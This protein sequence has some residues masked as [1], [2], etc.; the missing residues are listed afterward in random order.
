MGEALGLVY[1]R[2]LLAYLVYALSA[3]ACSVPRDVSVNAVF[4]I[5]III[6]FDF[7]FLMFAHKIRRGGLKPHPLPC[8]TTCS[9][10]DERNN[11][12][13]TIFRN[14]LV[15]GKALAHRFPGL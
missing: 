9:R 15:L 4:H 8:Q 11:A 14:I 2:L 12:G 3:G 5:R 6:P 1:L 10:T 7:F 13:L